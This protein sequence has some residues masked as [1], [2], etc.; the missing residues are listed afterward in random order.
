MY[1]SV[2]IAGDGGYTSCT[3]LGRPCPSGCLGTYRR[4]SN[5]MLNPRS[6]HLPALLLNIF[7]YY[8]YYL[9]ELLPLLMAF[10]IGVQDPCKKQGTHH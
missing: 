9:I 7:S 4:D 3:S 6:C 8:S 2:K 1:I 5:L 10:G